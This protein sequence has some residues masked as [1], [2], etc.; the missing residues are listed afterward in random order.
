M[1]KKPRGF[2]FKLAAILA[3]LFVAS[4]IAVRVIVALIGPPYDE[5]GDPNDDTDMVALKA[6]LAGVPDDPNRTRIVFVGD[7]YTKGVAGIKPDQTY[8]HEV[9]VLL[10]KWR[11]GRYTVISLGLSGNDCVGEWVVYHRFQDVAR[12]D[13]VVQVLSPRALDVGACTELFAIQ[14]FNSQRIFTSKVSKISDLIEESIRYR[15][16]R[17][18]FVDYVRGGATQ[19][20]RERAWRIFSRETIATR[21]LVEEGGAI[22]VMGFFPLV[23]FTG[24]YPVADVHRQIA[25]FAADLKVPYV[26][27]LDAFQGQDLGK[28]GCWE[29]DLHPGRTAHKIAGKAMADFLTQSI[30]PKLPAPTTNKATKPRTSQE[31]AAAEVQHLRELLRMDPTCLAAQFWLGRVMSQTSQANK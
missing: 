18:R 25:A 29:G 27:L 1:A 31:I 3:G 15:K 4:E 11:P 28:M 16:S 22:Y 14:E 24:A 12:A 2:W 17:K 30:L 7:S 10:E 13:L 20:Q 5:P 26:E 19:P 8:V 6:T 9:G 23:G 21:R